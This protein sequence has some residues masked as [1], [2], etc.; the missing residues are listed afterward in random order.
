MTH[1]EEYKRLIDSG[2][3][4]AC[5]YLKKEIDNL[6]AE[7]KDPRFVYDTTDADKRIAFLERC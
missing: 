5:R 3:V 4:I 2:E 6:V 7:M 1:L